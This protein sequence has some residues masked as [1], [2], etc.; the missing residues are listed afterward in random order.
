MFVIWERIYAK[1]VVCH[2]IFVWLWIVWISCYEQKIQTKECMVEKYENLK[3]LFS[4]G[5]M[6]E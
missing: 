1:P 4:L 5:I 3:K 6:Q 2:F